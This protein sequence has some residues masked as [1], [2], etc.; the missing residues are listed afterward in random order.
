MLSRSNRV[1][2]WVDQLPLETVQR[3]MHLV[4]PET[5]NWKF[6]HNDVLDIDKDI[7]DH[8]QWKDWAQPQSTRLV[9][10]VQPPWILSPQDLQNF[11][12]CELVRP[13]FIR[14]Y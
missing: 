4:Y 10:V 6:V 12:N 3:T 2:V 1:S 5:Q 14:T 13:I 9:V 11:Q 8:F 7:F